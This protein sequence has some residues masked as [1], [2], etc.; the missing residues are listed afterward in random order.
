METTEYAVHAS[1]RR[2]FQIRVTERLSPVK[3]SAKGSNYFFSLINVIRFASVNI[4]S[5]SPTS[6]FPYSD[7][8]YSVIP[9]PYSIFP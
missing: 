7:F 9:Y 3:L 6:I 2:S 4:D 1:A 5:H 8:P